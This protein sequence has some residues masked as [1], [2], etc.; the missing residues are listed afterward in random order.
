[1][2]NGVYK[3]AVGAE[4]L[5]ACPDLAPLVRIVKA[6]ARKKGLN[7]PKTGTLNSFCL[8]QLCQFH[9]QT[10]RVPR[11]PPLW[12]LLPYGTG[13]APP[14]SARRPMH[15]GA[16]APASALAATTAGVTRWLKS[17]AADAAAPP[18]LPLDTLT[19]SFFIHLG[20]FTL[21]QICGYGDAAAA[22]PGYGHDSGPMAVWTR[23]DDVIDTRP[24]ALPL[25]LACI[26]FTFCTAVYGQ[27]RQRC[28]ACGALCPAVR[29]QCRTLR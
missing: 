7:A 2:D 8:T 21:Y 18:P 11:L 23:P 15:D 10:L 16:R 1:M 17:R 20:A 29:R 12:T 19:L 26:L 6:W 3:G 27:Y 13:D 14:P 9:L 5:A 28:S 22:A 4:L 25:A 24:G